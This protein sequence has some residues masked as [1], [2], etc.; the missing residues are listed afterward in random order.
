ML[1]TK[2]KIIGESDIPLNGPA[3][4]VL[5][6]FNIYYIYERTISIL[7]FKINGKY[8]IVLMLTLA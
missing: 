3:R 6:Y 2:N 5:E 8:L 4:L 1:H 7:L